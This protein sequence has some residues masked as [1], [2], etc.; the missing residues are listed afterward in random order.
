MKDVDSGK[1]KS[2]S[3]VGKSGVK[4]EKGIPLDA[5]IIN[6]NVITVD[7]NMSRAEA[8]GILNG[9]IVAVGSN[10]EIESM[11]GSKT[12]V[13]DAKGK[14]VVPGFHDSHMHPLLVGHFARG[15]YLTDVKDIPEMLERIKQK[16]KE[17]PKGEMILGFGWNQERMAE[18]RYPTRWEVD[19]VAPDHPVF[20]IHWNAHI[21]LINTML[22]NQKGIT[23]D[24]PDPPGG[25]I[26]KDDKGEPTGVLLENAIDLIAPGFLET[27]AGLFSYEQSKAALKY[28]VD[29]AAEWGLTSIVDILAGDAQVKA[30]Q[31]LE[32]EGKLP[33]RVNF[34]LGFQYLDY[35]IK[36]GIKSGFGSSKVRL[37]GA[38]MIVDG[39]LSSHTAALREPYADMPDNRGVMRLTYEEIRAF[40]ENATKNGIRVDIHALGDGAIETVLK[41]FRET[42][43]KYNVKDPRFKI[44][45]CIIHAPDLI[46]QFK[47]MNVIANVQP[48]FIMK[49]QHWIPRLVGPQREKYAH[50]YRSMMEAGIHMCSGT[51]A[52]IETMNPIMNI[53]AASV[54]KDAQGVP[55][56]GWHPEQRIPVEH[57]L[58]MVTIEG[59]YATGEEHVKGSI[60]VGKYADIVILSDDPLGVEPDKI[61]DIRVLLTMVGGEVV[62]SKM[63]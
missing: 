55:K 22:M 30:Y 41:I 38:K 29:R 15:V 28:C 43:N 56:G 25:T 31:E 9:V 4:K 6:A 11:I 13:I 50:P 34:Y 37:A 20:L 24:T 51:D 49:G 18:K 36:L 10:K 16:V 44:S 62:H 1:K 19:T 32:A 57:A 53:Y 63:E 27:G 59:A 45:H 12:K 8:V 7:K 52:P 35:L 48:V 60:E 58:K 54:R 17:T 42:L 46:E 26:V 47:E 61:K 21:Y 40:V 2:G 5:A 23:K 33:V 3:R 14:T 39:S